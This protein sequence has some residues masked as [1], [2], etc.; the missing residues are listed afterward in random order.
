M[1]HSLPTHRL[2]WVTI[3][4]LL[5]LLLACEMVP[6]LDQP[7]VAIESISLVEN[8]F[9][10]PKFRIG[11]RITNPNAFDLPIKGLSYAIRV[12]DTEVFQGVSNGLDP[13]P[14]YGEISVSVVLGA[15]LLRAGSLIKQIMLKPTSAL[16][17]NLTGKM[18]FQGLW[19]TVNFDE[20]GSVPLNI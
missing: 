16:T 19:P 18:D 14:A 2:Q 17:Y 10:V 1:S 12:Q 15:N 13:I 8:N 3:V 6:K 11:L 4:L 20:S 9:L 7:K 5:P